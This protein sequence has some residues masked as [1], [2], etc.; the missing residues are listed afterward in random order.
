MEVSKSTLGTTVSTQ[1]HGLEEEEEEE[2]KRPTCDPG[3]LS[4]AAAAAVTMET[5]VN[6]LP[7]GGTAPCKTHAAFFTPDILFVFDLR[8]LFFIFIFFFSNR[9][10]PPRREP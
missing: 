2:A 5:H 8:S 1:Q 10:K 3:S 6:R 7:P 9:V 4:P